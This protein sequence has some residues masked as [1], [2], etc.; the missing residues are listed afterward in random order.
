MPVYYGRKIVGFRNRPS[1]R[2]MIFLLK[3]NN[4]EKFVEPLRRRRK[5]K[6]DSRAI[7][8]RSAA[9]ASFSWKRMSRALRN[10]SLSGDSGRR[11]TRR[12]TPESA[13][14][15]VNGSVPM[16]ALQADLPIS[17]PAPV[18][19]R[20]PD[21]GEFAPEAPEVGA[22]GCLA[23]STRERL[24]RGQGLAPAPQQAHVQCLRPDT[25]HW[26]RS[27]V[28]ATHRP[29]PAPVQRNA[30]GQGDFWLRMAS[31]R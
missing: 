13:A 22:Q 28:S 9:S 6:P 5:R 30:G 8:R 4:P 7:S 31:W 24:R 27:P 12:K 16:V 21:G 10:Q 3:A 17:E 23:D 29:T 26:R 14:A 18:A 20:K 11:G 25:D 19:T 2:L 1:D 15:P